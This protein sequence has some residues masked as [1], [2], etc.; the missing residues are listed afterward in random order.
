[1]TTYKT[2]RP[3]VRIEM[4]AVADGVK[5]RTSVAGMGYLGTRDIAL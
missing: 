4:I 5:N 2:R 1:M 3:T